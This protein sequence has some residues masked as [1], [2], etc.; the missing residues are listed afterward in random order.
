MVRAFLRQVVLRGSLLLCLASLSLASTPP[1]PLVGYPVGRDFVYPDSAR[2]GRDVRL[3]ADPLGRLTAVGDGVHLVQDGKSWLTLGN[4]RSDLDRLLCVDYVSGGGGYFASTNACGTLEFLPG[5]GVRH[6]SRLP[7]PAPGWTANAQFTQLV[8][9]PGGVC[10]VSSRGIVLMDQSEAVG[11]ALPLDNVL[12]A[13]VVGDVLH[14]TSGSLGMFRVDTR[15]GRLVPAG[16]GTN[17]LLYRAARWDARSVLGVTV[18]NE[19]VLFD[20]ERT[21]SI[22]PAPDQTTGLSVS[23]I[24]KLGDHLMA[25]AVKGGGLHFIDV[26]GTPVLSLREP[27]LQTVSDLFVGEPGV[28]WAACAT[29]VRK[30]HYNVPVAAFDHRSGLNLLWP[31]LVRHRGELLVVS[32]GSV[33]RAT[34]GKVAEPTRFDPIPLPAAPGVWA[35]ASVAQGLLVGNDEGV[36]LWDGTALSPVF[37]RF[38]VYRI[39]PL[40]PETTLLVGQK[41]VA[42]VSWRDQR[43]AVLAEADAAGFPHHCVRY[44]AEI[45]WVEHGGGS[46]SRVHWDGTGL[47]V[48][49]FS[50]WGRSGWTHLGLIDDIVVLSGGG[51]HRAFFD[52]GKGELVAKPELE[53]ILDLSPRRA[54]R[55]VKTKRG[56]L[57]LTHNGG[58]DRL[59]P[60]PEGGYVRNY[61]GLDVVSQTYPALQAPTEDEI[62][63]SSARDLVRL[64]DKPGEESSNSRPVLVS[65]VQRDTE[66]PL[67]DSLRPGQGSLSE[68]PYASGGLVFRVFAGGYARMV[69]PEFQYK[70]HGDLDQWSP[71][72]TDS[73]ISVGRLREGRYELLVRIVESGQPL[74][75]PLSVRFTIAP[76]PYR[77]WWAYLCY[78]VGIVALTG[79][80]VSFLVFRE[81]RQRE[82]LEELVRLRTRDLEEAAEEARQAARAKSQFLANMSHEIRTPMNGVIGM[83][84]LLMH[85]PLTPEQREFAETIQTSGESL[86]VVINDILDFS[87]LEAGKLALEQ[88][89]FDLRELIGDVVRLLGPAA[90][91]KGITL[92][93]E[94]APSLSPCYAGDA[95]RLRQVLLNLVG[96]AV[97]FTAHG[98]VRLRVRPGV[99][100]PGAQ[101]HPL[102]VDVEDTGIGLSV[103]TQAQLFQPF[104]QAD[105]STTRRFGGTGLGLAISKQI[106]DR[107]DGK[108]GV[109]STPGCG[110]LFWIEFVLTPADCDVV[111]C[112]AARTGGEDTFP[113]R[114]IRILVA[115]DNPV[116]QKVVERQ[117]VGLG[118]QVTCAGTGRAA[119][120]AL[121][122]SAFDLVL[123]DCH[124]PEMDGYE[125]TARIR[126]EV[127]PNLPIIAFTAN[128][129][130]AERQRC[131]D[132]GMNACLT[133]P[134]RFHEL[135]A[136]LLQV[137]SQQC[138]SA[139]AGP[140][141][142]TRA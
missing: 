71:P 3:T 129:L 113:L 15:A 31:V 16:P 92:E 57:W 29:G 103:E 139:E 49:D 140:P 13:F 99:S 73:A 36:Q 80:A 27:E 112:V 114:G 22:G 133:K 2:P 10:A 106:V 25:V 127:S 141:L 109:E 91:A 131:F 43:W 121:R 33:Y 123:M 1:A 26:E 69:S 63:V 100:V 96:N 38:T 50:P 28:L 21:Q 23:D 12:T 51:G 130:P 40:G 9:Y 37:N 34:P 98:F 42:V 6:L 142:A 20:G 61:A 82:R 62:W 122:T 117:L 78:G 74:G 116:N 8:A 126:A 52:E 137:V 45:V 102:R 88:R 67:Y 120:D 72:Q 68:I 85:T 115:E 56:T 124:M 55:I 66:L 53:A 81:R 118:C 101:G 65:V 104:M 134:V 44:N 136:V 70:L 11:R 17:P 94:V 64:S 5:G 111:P 77:T 18:A 107:M 19:L 30:I 58:V 89:P 119:V 41:R 138:T 32:N 59:S 4:E 79:A 87:K 48:R 14:I 75:E 95:A 90:R 135:K 105:A 97:K 93:A 86:L 132:V 24:V 47:Q 84:H 60:T 108:I 76:P 35:A 110:A 125:A 39:V 46:V 54:L 7:S 83:T 128:A